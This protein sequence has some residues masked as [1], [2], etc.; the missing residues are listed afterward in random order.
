M[1]FVLCF[2]GQLR[3]EQTFKWPGAPAK[4]G[5]TSSSDDTAGCRTDFTHGLLPPSH[6]HWVANARNIYKY[7]S[8]V[9]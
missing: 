2:D 9:P 5:V 8:A 6:A 7:V 3:Q 1:H 4:L